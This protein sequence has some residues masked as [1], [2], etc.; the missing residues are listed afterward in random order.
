MN[1][2]FFAHRFFRKSSQVSLNQ[3]VADNLPMS[4]LA[5]LTRIS[6]FGGKEPVKPAWSAP[7]QSV[8]CSRLQISRCFYR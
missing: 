1:F 8:D 4:Q 7:A 3:L 2:R 6:W 5:L